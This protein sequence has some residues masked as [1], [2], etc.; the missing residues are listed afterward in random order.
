M[1]E[2]AEAGVKLVFDTSD[3]KG[4]LDEL[5][6]Q[7]D[8]FSSQDV[9]VNVVANTS[10]AE[11]AISGVD[12]EEPE[13]KAKVTTDKDSTSLLSSLHDLADL[14]AH[15]WNLVVN[16]AGTA[17]DFFGKVNEFGIQPLLD[18]DQ[19]V[20]TFNAHTGEALP[21]A[22]ELFS[23]ILYDDLG[24]DINQVEAVAEAAAK[25]G[26]PIDEA[27]RAALEFT[28]TFTD[29]DPTEVLKT[30]DTMVKTGLAPDFKT[31]G[32]LLT[33]AFQNSDDKG[34]DLLGTIQNNAGAIKDLGLTGPEYLQDL[35]NAL[36]NGADSAS[37][38]TTGLEAIKK[39]IQTQ[40]SG[41][42]GGAALSVLNQLGIENPET[43]AEGWTNEF[44]L[45]VADAIKNYKGTDAQ[46]QAMFSKLTGGKLG[47]K[48]YEWFVNLDAAQGEFDK[49]T[50]ASA[51]AASNM[52]NSLKGAI[53]D[54][55]L[56]AQGAF[57]NFLSDS[58]IDLPG[59]IQKLKEGI[60][61][62][63]KTLQSGGSLADALAITL[64]PLGFDDEFQKLENIFGEFIINLLLVIADI[65]DVLRQPEQA[66]ATRSTAA[67][68]AQNQLAFQAKIDNPEELAQD[69]QDA[70]ARGVTPE[71]IT[72][73]VGTAVDELVKSGATAQAQALL[74]Q[75]KAQQQVVATSQPLVGEAT[76]VKLPITPDMTQADIDALKKKAVDM[77]NA[78]TGGAPVTSLDIQEVNVDKDAI[79]AMQ[80]QITDGI[81]QAQLEAAKEATVTPTPTMQPIAGVGA[82]LIDPRQLAEQ[83]AN[84]TQL[85]NDKITNLA[86]PMGDLSDK[87]D[88]SKTNIQQFNQS[89]DD[90]Q[91][92]MEKVHGSADNIRGSMD[93]LATSTDTA[94]TAVT[95]QTTAATN[96][97]TQTPPATQA[98]QKQAD[99]NSQLTMHTDP[100]VGSI[101]LLGQKTDA[102]SVSSIVTAGSLDNLNGT[103]TKLGQTAAAA[104]SAGVNANAATPPVTAPTH[105]KGGIFSGMSWV[106]E[107]GPELMSSDTRM[108]VLN[109]RTAKGL[110]QALSG[111]PFVSG[112]GYSGGGGK[113]VVLNQT[114]IVNNEAQADAL[115]YATGKYVRGMA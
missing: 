98:I 13:V 97:A 72:K 76:S 71:G 26:D 45:Q 106:G 64:K 19:A 41:G 37:Q 70:L 3:A 86:T 96:L 9:E 95:E 1:T 11:D 80:Q 48:D 81:H 25:L 63:L 14:G 7:I 36:K 65:Q 58:N 42:K 5:Q 43:S 84:A 68:M 91:V 115:G 77:L 57:T 93:E 10:E 62:G 2:Y 109:N 15:A 16:I 74:D 28:H 79:A 101:T 47:Q 108:A 113:S 103:I 56:A 59:K 33:T 39:N 51:I 55:I 105:A 104:N 69:M 112:G 67:G 94:T 24:T 40:T 17:V 90:A 66:A 44:F 83:T 60:Q 6:T 82:G 88:K 38:V 89:L 85:V 50:G 32:D 53:N 12:R 20:A 52:D 46:K 87:T 100:A 111:M 107:N 30:M 4:S 61:N 34:G 102:V 31:A 29:E 75:F 54:F 110:M 78:Q 8:A 23:N 27:T 49:V 99:A 21:N 114:N 73:A 22:R 18:L 35:N 92:P